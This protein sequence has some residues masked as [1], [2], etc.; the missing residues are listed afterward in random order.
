METHE[1]RTPG[2]MRRHTTLS[3]IA[4]LLNLQRKKNTN[5][6]NLLTSNFGCEKTWASNFKI[7]RK[8]MLCLFM[9]DVRIKVFLDIK[10]SENVLQVDKSRGEGWLNSNQRIVKNE[11][12]THF[13]G[14]P[15][16]LWW[17][18]HQ[19]AGVTAM[20]DLDKAGLTVLLWNPHNLIF[21]LLL[22]LL[23]SHQSK[24][25]SD[26]HFFELLVLNSK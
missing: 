20:T 16:P 6:T 1:F 9:W 17:K 4:V 26:L 3:K 5:N 15:L 22:P 8:V 25:L 2:I 11:V 24:I 10:D 18:T 12:T 7:L 19:T 14:T 13:P 23:P 21:W